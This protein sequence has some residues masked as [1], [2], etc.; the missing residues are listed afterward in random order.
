MQYTHICTHIH[1]YTH[2][3]LHTCTCTFTHIYICV[4]VNV[5]VWKF[6]VVKSFLYIFHKGDDSMSSREI[7]TKTKLFIVDFFFFK[8]FNDSI[9]H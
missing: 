1:V 6:V 3:Y 2:I 7:F 4:C 8:K 5:H 9:I